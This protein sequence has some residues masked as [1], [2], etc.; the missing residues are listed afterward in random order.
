MLL[1]VGATG[2][3]GNAYF[4]EYNGKILLLDAGIPIKEIKKHI[5]FRVGD[6]QA[7]LITHEHL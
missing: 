1:K 4:L 2:S 5:G 6:I 3:S 7:A